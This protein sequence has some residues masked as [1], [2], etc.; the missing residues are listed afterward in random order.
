MKNEQSL[1]AFI[2]LCRSFYDVSDAAK[3]NIKTFGLSL[4]EFETLELL[5]HKGEQPIQDIGK[6]VLLTSGSMTY[7]VNQL[8]MKGFVQRIRCEQDRRVYYAKITTE[9]KALMSQIFP[10]HGACIATAFHNL[11]EEELARLTQLLQ[12]I[13]NND[14]ERQK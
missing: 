9:G 6:R 14:T 5:Y 3:K 10:E 2:A 1:R 7:V 11:S 4:S 12:K 8:S 13:R